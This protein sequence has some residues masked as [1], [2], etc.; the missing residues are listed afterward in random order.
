MEDGLRPGHQNRRSRRNVATLADDISV[1]LLDISNCMYLAVPT[2]VGSHCKL[3]FGSWVCGTRSQS[4]ECLLRIRF[5]KLFRVV[6]PDVRSMKYVLV[7]VQ[8]APFPSW[9]ELF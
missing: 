5:S 7:A 4:M 8:Q 9:E 6:L 3:H 1:V 2:V